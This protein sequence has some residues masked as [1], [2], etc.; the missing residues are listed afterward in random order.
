MLSKSLKYYPD[1]PFLKL[2]IAEVEISMQLGHAAKKTLDGLSKLDWSKDYSPGMLA[3][4]D[5][6]KAEAELQ[7]V[8]AEKTQE[9][10][11]TKR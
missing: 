7:S 4:I 5:K 9:E 1:D 8:K 3:Y 2:R 6:L 11:K 10:I